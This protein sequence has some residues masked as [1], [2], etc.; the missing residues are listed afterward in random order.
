MTNYA[1]PGAWVAL[2]T[3]SAGYDMVDN[4][5]Y[6]FLCTTSGTSASV[7]PSWPSTA[8]ATVA[9]GTAVWTNVMR[10]RKAWTAS[11]AYSTQPL[12]TQYRWPD[13]IVT[14]ASVGAPVVQCVVSGTSG[15]VKPVWPTTLG[16]TVTDGTVLWA[17]VGL[18]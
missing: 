14:A 11:T 1:G 13:Q 8:G 15:S 17:T 5:T 18:N 12:T 10:T 16:Q 6:Y 9:D 3:Y 7:A 2:T 4:G